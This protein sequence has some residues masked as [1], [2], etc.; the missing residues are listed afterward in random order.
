V[1]REELGAD[2]MQHAHVNGQPGAVFRNTDVDA[3]L[4]VSLDIADGLIQAFRT[5][6][7]PEKLRH[8]G[9]GVSHR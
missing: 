8:L 1:W 2:E 7:N 6:T 9:R 3:V 5:I 4:V